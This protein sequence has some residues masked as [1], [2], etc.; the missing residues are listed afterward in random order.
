MTHKLENYVK[1][2]VEQTDCSKSERE[3]LY[4]EMLSHVM[5]RREE[6]R[7]KGKTEKEAEEEAMKLFGREAKIGDGLQ[8]AMFPYRRELLLLLALL[9]FLFTFGKYTAV[10]VQEQTALL[11]ILSGTAGHSAVLFF[12]LNRAFAV[13]RKIW[14]A[15]A[16][17]LNLL[18]L[19]LNMTS[20]YGGWQ[21]AYLL[22][23]GLNIYLMYR[24]VLTYER[25]KEHKTARRIIHVVNITLGLAAGLGEGYIYLIAMGF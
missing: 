4:E 10:L 8:Q 15:L 5:M 9:G 22:M 1:R 17:L 18:L 19:L 20:F 21:P 23:I 16:L 3:D 11:P 7:Q 24:T 14:L 13:N 6:E 12:A 2:I 25:P